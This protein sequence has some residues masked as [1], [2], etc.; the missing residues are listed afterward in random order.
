MP[1]S[2]K[3]LLLRHR[4]WQPHQLCFSGQ[5]TGA[6]VDGSIDGALNEPTIVYCKPRQAAVKVQGERVANYR[7]SH[8]LSVWLPGRALQCLLTAPYWRSTLCF[9]R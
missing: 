2:G 7:P 5:S 9:T 8:H 4:P 1:A 6:K 3:D